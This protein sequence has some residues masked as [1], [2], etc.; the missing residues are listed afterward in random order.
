[1]KAIVAGLF[2]IATI[3]I[4][5]NNLSKKEEIISVTIPEPKYNKKLI[6]SS[7]TSTISS[8]SLSICTV[9]ENKLVCK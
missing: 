9:V 3:A 2:V 4:L 1:M 6:Q 7:P 5:Y 8:M